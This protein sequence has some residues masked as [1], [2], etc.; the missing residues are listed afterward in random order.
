MRVVEDLQCRWLQ[1]LSN[2]HKQ[3][4]LHILMVSKPNRLRGRELPFA[5]RASSIGVMDCDIADR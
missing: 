4:V 3:S 1:S 5:R 2:L